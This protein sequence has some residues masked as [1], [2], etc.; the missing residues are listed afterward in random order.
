MENT[1]VTSA[2]TPRS[3]APN[4][5]TGNVV[6]TA[7]SGV[8]PAFWI[9]VAAAMTLNQSPA[10]LDTCPSQCDG[11]PQRVALHAHGRCVDEV[12]PGVE[13]SVEHATHC[14]VPA[15]QETDGGGTEA[16]A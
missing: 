4:S 8:L 5:A 7:T 15:L 14:L 16:E 12:H 2:A 11:Q 13:R 6:A 1:Q 3:S 10:R 9:S